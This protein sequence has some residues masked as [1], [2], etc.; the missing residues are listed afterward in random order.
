MGEHQRR[1]TEVKRPK[2]NELRNE[3][4]MKTSVRDVPISSIPHDKD[5]VY[6]EIGTND[7]LA[8]LVQLRFPG[9]YRPSLPNTGFPCYPTVQLPCDW[10]P[11]SQ[12]VSSDKVTD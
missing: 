2:M 7:I 3:P 10:C 12:P 8:R 9:V 6:T 5:D 4:G 11:F 1:K